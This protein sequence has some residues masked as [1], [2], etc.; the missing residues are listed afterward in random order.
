[1]NIFRRV[2]RLEYMLAGTQSKMPVVDYCG[3][4]CYKV[5][6]LGDGAKQN[7]Y[8]GMSINWTQAGGCKLEELESEITDKPYYAWKQ[9][10]RTDIQDE[11]DNKIKIENIWM[12]K[13]NVFYYDDI[14]APIRSKIEKA[15]KVKEKI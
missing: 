10:K 6:P 5:V 3:E 7:N 8:Y 1:M 2:K 15:N 13:K 4:Y 12:N 14:Y 11:I 9:F